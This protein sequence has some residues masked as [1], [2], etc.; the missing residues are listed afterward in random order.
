M[1]KWGVLRCALTAHL[2]HLTHV[3]PGGCSEPANALHSPV[4]RWFVVRPPLPLLIFIT[5]SF[6]GRGR[7]L[8]NRLFLTQRFPWSHQQELGE[9]RFSCSH[10]SVFGHTRALAVPSVINLLPP[11][12]EA[13]L[14]RRR[15]PFGGPLRQRWTLDRP[16]GLHKSPCLGQSLCSL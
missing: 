13:V 16:S 14:N 12:S 3:V 11:A 9:G 15:R 1:P 6:R 5:P 4:S 2:S 7:A 10:F 8:V